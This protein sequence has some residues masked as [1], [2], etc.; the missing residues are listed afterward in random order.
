MASY[1]Y[2][3]F[4]EDGHLMC[5]V[6]HH[7]KGV[8]DLDKKEE[9]NERVP[10]ETKHRQRSVH[11]RISRYNR[12]ATGKTPSDGSTPGTRR[13]FCLTFANKLPRNNG[14]STS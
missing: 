13:S 3:I 1:C 2:L 8:C 7:K 12:E 14:K 10:R 6:N 5:T 9:Q 11:G 4:G